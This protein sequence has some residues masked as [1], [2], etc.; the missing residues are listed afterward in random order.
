MGGIIGLTIRLELGCEWRGSCWTNVLPEGLF[1]APFYVDLDSSKQHT[2]AWLE[3]LVARRKTDPELEEVWGGWDKL[4]PIEYG[5]VVVDYVTNTLVSCQGYSGVDYVYCHEYN[6]DKMEKYDA[7]EKAGLLI[8]PSRRDFPAHW[9]AAD[10]KLPF[11]NTII[12]DYD[13]CDE[14]LYGWCDRHFTLTDEERDAWME[15]FAAR[16]E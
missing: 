7:L 1:A 3:K 15:W 11:A 12:G 9:K 14:I 2:S 16:D 4:A 13:R 10:I 6:T 8:V 5:L